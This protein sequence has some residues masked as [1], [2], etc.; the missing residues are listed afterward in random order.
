MYAHID[1]VKPVKIAPGVY[2]R[3]LI[4][5]EKTRPG[6]LGVRHYVLEEDATVSG[7]KNNLKLL[8]SK[9][10]KITKM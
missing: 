7:N 2:E 9:T 1:N 8:D 5:P 4:K 3:V 6:G 10:V